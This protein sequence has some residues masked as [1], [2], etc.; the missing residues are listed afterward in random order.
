MKNI[1][2]IL[3]VIISVCLV[4]GILAACT[5]GPKPANPTEQP[6][7]TEAP[8]DEG[9]FIDPADLV[10]QEIDDADAI[11][12]TDYT[13]VYDKIGT[14]VTIDMVTENPDGTATVTVD[15]ITYT[16][17]MDFLSMAMV[18]NTTVPE[19]SETYKSADDVYNMW[20]K[21]YIQRW[22]LLVAEVPLYSNQYFDLYNAKFE[23]F[24][25]SPYWGAADAIVATTVKAGEDNSAILG[26]STDLSG[27]FRNASWGKSSP[28]A[29]DNDVMSLTSGYST[30]M[31]DISG[32]YIWNMSALAEEPKEVINEDG[33]LTYTI[34][35]KEGLVFSDGS[36]INAKNYIVA[37]L[38]NSTLVAEEAGG[39]GRSGLQ[40]VGYKDFHDG[41]AQYFEGVK[42]I[43]DYTFSVTFTSDYAGY[44]YS[45]TYAGFGP[46][47]LPLYLGSKGEIIVDEATKA[48]GLNEAFYAKTGESYDMAA[49]IKANMAWD[50]ALPYSG[51]YVVSNYDDSNKIAT[52]KINDKYPGDDARGKAS[53]ET[54]TY[55]K[56]ISETQMNQFKAGEVDVIA[57]ITGGNDTRAA[58]QVVEENPTKYA[59]THYDRAGYGKLGFRGDFGPSMFQ[60]VRQAIM[61]TINRNEFAEAFTGGFGSVVHGAY[62]TGFSAFQAVKDT[63]NLNAYTYS[64]DKAIQTLEADGWIYNSKGGKFVAGTDDVRYKKLSGYELTKYNLH[65]STVDGKYKTVKLND[66]YYMPLAINYYGTQPNEVTDLLVSQ[67]QTSKVAT[68]DIG[69]Y[70][71]YI[72]CEFQPGVYGQLCWMED[73]GFDGTP[74]LNCINFAS[75]FNSAAYDYA[76]NWTLD[77]DMYD[78]ASAYYIMDAA[79][80]WADYQ[81]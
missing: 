24:V 70:I 71:Q 18:Y 81:K 40:L 4:L 62:Y 31:S 56:V 79:D 42:L 66:N 22:N 53:I 16:L 23:N 3:S 64:S 47:P 50:S 74:T 8:V 37:L 77:Q 21:L 58:L 9:D 48:C 39:S 43:D 80:F 54:I 67:W 1:M 69:M 60:S 36:A 35:I 51:P 14:K 55:V 34:K 27:L 33:T 73:Y 52:L 15:G 72:S 5:E 78:E 46:D 30:V 68:T 17:G 76:F 13:S 61:Y 44:Y 25:T 32:A 45:I 19:G 12:R 38:G 11:E 2:K 65:F 63:I 41:K 10:V 20:W 7:N 59:E 57:G 29:S 28:A 26:S 75:S 6:G 49:E